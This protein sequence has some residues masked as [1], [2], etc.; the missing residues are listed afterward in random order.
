MKENDCYLI[1]NSN[2]PAKTAEFYEA[3]GLTVTNGHPLGDYLVSTDIGYIT[4]NQSNIDENFTTQ[5]YKPIINLDLTRA[6]IDRVV[7]KITDLGS[8][9]TETG[10]FLN[11]IGYECGDFSGGT[12]SLHIGI[13]S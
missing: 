1:I 8:N 7:K 12:I 11:M 3:V 4:I 9:V 2:N 13:R 6:E 5:S 10:E